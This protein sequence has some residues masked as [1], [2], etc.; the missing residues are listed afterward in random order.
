MENKFLKIRLFAP[1]ISAFVV[2]SIKSGYYIWDTVKMDSLSKFV[3]ALVAGVL[4]YFL[5]KSIKNTWL[6]FLLHLVSTVF[7]TVILVI[8]LIIF[9]IGMYGF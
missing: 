2:L 3:V 5:A 1:I 6:F 9:M 8:A 7:M 4:S